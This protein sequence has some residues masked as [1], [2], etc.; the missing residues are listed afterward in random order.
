MKTE[1]Y[2]SKLES[3]KKLIED[4]LNAIG[5]MDKDTGDWEATPEAQTAPEADESDM[6][7]RTEEY[8]E[9]SGTAATL[10]A[11]LDDVDLALSK[12]ANGTYGTCESCGALIE[13]ERLDANASAR[14]CIECMN[15]VS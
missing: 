11:R 1:I 14:T 10:N 2:K 15:K 5:K 7:D 3:E 9:R 6:A 12:I 13:E 4:E 8:E